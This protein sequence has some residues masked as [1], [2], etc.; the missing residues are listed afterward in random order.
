MKVSV[1]SDIPNLGNRMRITKTLSNDLQM[2][3]LN[4]SQKLNHITIRREKKSMIQE[5]QKDE[6]LREKSNSENEP[7]AHGITLSN[8]GSLL[9]ILEDLL[10]DNTKVKQPIDLLARQSIGECTTERIVD[11]A[12]KAPDQRLDGKFVSKNVFNLSHRAL[13]EHE[14]SVLDKE[15]NFVPT[16]EKLD[17]LQIKS[18]PEQLGRDIKLRMYFKDNPTPAFAEKLAFKVRSTWTP[19]LEML[20]WNFILVKLKIS[21]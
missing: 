18:D 14:I 19:L 3:C 12:P 1:Q 6:K 13:T 5:K 11:N 4:Y 8:D 7:K 17:R 20:N 21:F 10:A 16:P 9:D 15:L 2:V